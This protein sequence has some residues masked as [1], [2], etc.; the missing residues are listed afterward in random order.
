MKKSIGLTLA[1]FL[2]TVFS[3]SAQITFGVKGGVNI[4]KIH[5]SEDIIKSDNLTGFQIGPMMEFTVP[6]LGIGMDAAVLYSQKGLEVNSES[7]KADYLDVPVNLK[8]K[9]GLPIVKGYFTAGPYASFRIG[10]DKI[11]NVLDTQIKA[12][13][14]GTGLNFGAGVEVIKHLQVGFNYDL[15]LTNS[16]TGDNNTGD[17]KHRGWSI[18]A[19]ILF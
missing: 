4:S 19:A 7:H 9:F 11:W 16:Y 8:W 14:F 17:G 13:S 10:G 5:F 2:L 12:K 3:A 18:T 6:I 15:G 1:V